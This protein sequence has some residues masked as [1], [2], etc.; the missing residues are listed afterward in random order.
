VIGRAEVNPLMAQVVAGWHPEWYVLQI[1]PAHERIAAAHLIGRRF[2]IF[3]PEVEERRTTRGRRRRVLLPMFPGYVF[4]FAWLAPRNYDR[5]RSCPG[6]FD[7]LCVK[8]APAVISDAAINVVRAIE[9]KQQPL[10]VERDAVGMVKKRYRG[11]RRYRVVHN[12]QT[13]ND[14]E[15][16]GVHTWSALWDRGLDGNGRNRLLHQALGVE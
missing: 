8:Q 10:V 9:N 7:F 16:I 11:F 14:E 6:V 5:I 15:I 3:L 2:G 12:E 1:L 13:I 4:V